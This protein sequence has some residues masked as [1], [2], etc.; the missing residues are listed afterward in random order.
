MK[1][2]Q[3]VIQ[4]CSPSLLNYEPIFKNYGIGIG[5]CK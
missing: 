3:N 1:K 4:K 2:E 5:V